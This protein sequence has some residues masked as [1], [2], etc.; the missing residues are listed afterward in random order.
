L[1]R[2][3]YKD[4]PRKRMKSYSGEPKGGFNGWVTLLRRHISFQYGDET[5]RR[6]IVGEVALNSNWKI[7]DEAA[8]P[9]AHEIYTVGLELARASDALIEDA[10]AQALPKNAHGVVHASF[11]A[12]HRG[13]DVPR[14]LVTLFLAQDAFELLWEQSIESQGFYISGEVSGASYKSALIMDA[15]GVLAEL[16]VRQFEM[17]PLAELP[18]DAVERRHQM[19]FEQ[20]FKALA[21][22]PRHGYQYGQVFSDLAR[23][24]SQCDLSSQEDLATHVREI[25]QYLRET[26][27]GPKAGAPDTALNPYGMTAPDFEKTIAALDDKAKR[28]A[29]DDFGT[30]WRHFDVE[31]VI[32]NGQDKVGANAEGFRDVEEELNSL[33]AKLTSKPQVFSALLEWALLDALVYAECI[34]FAQVAF[35][36]KKLYGQRVPDRLS[37]APPV[38]KLLPALI[39]DGRQLGLEVL[40]I[41]ATLAVSYLLAAQSLNTAWVIAVGFT[42]VRWLQ[43]LLLSREPSSQVKEQLLLRRM[44]DIHGL[45]AHTDFNARQLREMVLDARKDGVVFSRWVLNILDARIKREG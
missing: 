24:A 9:Y 20:A 1:Y 5:P 15:Q 22:G 13:E 21:P 33:A 10:E 40:K 3:P 31:R 43:P 11:F 39:T 37:G 23:T 27:R 8:E 16:A 38:P 41:G 4:A 26:F 12:D 36:Q 28:E 44:L 45:L 6:K 32:V 34:G 25:L 42:A 7:V 35:S 18:L 2:D 29:R 19:Q 14:R 17:T 30:L